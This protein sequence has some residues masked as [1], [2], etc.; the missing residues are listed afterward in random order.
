MT[1]PTIPNVT[2][3]V[4]IILI[5][6]TT[7]APYNASSGSGGSGIGPA[8]SFT[9]PSGTIDPSI[10]GF[11]SGLGQAGTG[12]IKVTLSANTSW[13]GLPA[14]TDGQQLTVVVVA[15]NFTLTLLNNNGSTAQWP[16][17]A[18]GPFSANLNDSLSLIADTGLSK[19]ILQP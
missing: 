15:G 9:S 16:I 13:Q 6:P 10:T 14:G 7:G 19:W 3:P 1:A 5:D 11:T 4:A 18:S 17:L 2:S 8:I 12:R